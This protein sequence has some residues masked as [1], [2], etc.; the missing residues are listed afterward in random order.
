MGNCYDHGYRTR[1]LDRGIL[2]SYGPDQVRPVWVLRREITQGSCFRRFDQSGE[3]RI[4]AVRCDDSSIA[5]LPDPDQAI[6]FKEGAPGSRLIRWAR[7]G[8]ELPSLDDEGHRD[9]H[10]VVIV[11]PEGRKPILYLL[12][13]TP[14]SVFV[15][16]VASPCRRSHRKRTKRS[17][18]I[19]FVKRVSLQLA[20]DWFL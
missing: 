3:D 9:A 20:F 5:T 6:R 18:R 17:F 7:H 19:A 4:A 8:H 13:Q 12:R 15:L 2:R 16:P 11:P 14:S 1:D 10:H